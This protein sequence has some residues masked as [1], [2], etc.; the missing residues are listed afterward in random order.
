M[1]QEARSQQV[2]PGKEIK[3][4]LICLQTS[5]LSSYNV[6]TNPLEQEARAQE[7]VPEG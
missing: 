5:G 6:N 1:P 4:E 2:V 7:V 3:R